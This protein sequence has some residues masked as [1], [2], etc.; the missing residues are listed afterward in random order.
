M[1][2]LGLG[3]IFLSACAALLVGCVMPEETTGAASD[4]K[5]KSDG[6]GG[7]GGASGKPPT[8]PTNLFVELAD[9]NELAVD[10]NWNPS[11]GEPPISYDVFRNTTGSTT[12][13]NKIG[14]TSS[15]FYT[16]NTVE[17]AQNYYYAVKAKN[18]YGKSD[19]SNQAK[20]YVPA[21]GK[22]PSAFDLNGIH[23][24]ENTLFNELFWTESKGTAPI[25]YTVYRKGPISAPNYAV[26][27]G[28]MTERT[29]DDF[30]ITDSN[31]TYSYYVFAEN[32]YGDTNSNTIGLP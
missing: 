7:G 20:V 2:K 13:Y 15:A 3:L 10:L 1:N 4:L 28:P 29:Y 5:I 17:G 9:G 23:H 19:Y 27:V 8:A 6:D 22:A 32:Q 11:T 14:S 16:D 12:N 24:D 18:S 25:K 31:T 21:P 30:N 26:I